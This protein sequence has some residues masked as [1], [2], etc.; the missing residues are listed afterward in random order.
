[1][2]IMK[3]D[4]GRLATGLSVSL[5]APL[6]GALALVHCSSSSGAGES[7]GGNPLVDGAPPKADASGS[8]DAG[9]QDS[10]IAQIPCD[11]ANACST[12][13][14]CC[15]SF[16]VDT[17][18]DPRNCGACGVACGATQFCTG[19]A[20]DDAV[21][22]NVCANAA[23]TVVAD[24]YAVDI[25]AGV[26]LATALSS[27]SDAGVHVAVVQQAEPGVLVPVSDASARPNIGG[28]DTLV[29]GGSWWGQLSV[30]YMDNSGLT[31]VYLTNDGTTSHIYERASGAA[32]VTTLDTALT[33]QHDF[34]LLELAVEPIS[35]TLCF[36]GEGILS[37]GT[38]AAGYYGASVTVPGHAQYTASYYVYEWTDTN[39]DMVPD[40]GDTFTLVAQGD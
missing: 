8:V 31:P 12:A 26:E 32:L 17:Q 33:A 15:S 34:F 35:G 40:Q 22:T 1:L 38:A 36:F 18:R 11:A 21:F 10:G 28:G 24:P 16:C 27:C 3:M 7:S 14:T 13:L 19:K 23:V 6:F 25:E 39:G 30:A 20:C 37:P 4:S 2:V 5:I 9:A 29:A